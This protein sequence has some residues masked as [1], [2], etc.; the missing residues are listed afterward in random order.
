MSLSSWKLNG[1]E[2]DTIGVT[3][4]IKDDPADHPFHTEKVK[5]GNFV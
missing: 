1:E 2:A 5:K 3:A 4:K